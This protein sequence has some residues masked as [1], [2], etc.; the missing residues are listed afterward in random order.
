MRLARIVLLAV[1]ALG[2]APGAFAQGCAM[3]YTSAAAAGAAA[4]HSLRLGI[5]VLLLPALFLFVG[6]LAL[7]VRR[8][9]AATT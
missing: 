8:A 3:C 6:V 7:L 5:M 1:A 9:L 2:L 4:I